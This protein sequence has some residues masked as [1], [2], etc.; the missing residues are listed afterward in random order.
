M[1]EGTVADNKTPLSNEETNDNIGLDTARKPDTRPWKERVRLFFYNS[2]EGSFLGRTPLSW[3]QIIAFYICFFTCL[4]GFWLLCWF[5]FVTTTPELSEGP[6][7][8]QDKSI[9]GTNPGVGIRPQMKDE[10]LEQKANFMSKVTFSSTNKQPNLDYA[11]E[12]KASLTNY[13][14]PSSSFKTADL[15]ECGEPPYGLTE[16]G[17]KICVYLKLNRI[18]GWSPTPIDAD[19]I[20]KAGETWSEDFV[21]HWQSQDNKNFVWMSCKAQNKEEQTKFEEFEYFP[22]NRGIDLKFFP[23]TKKEDE[24]V[25]PAP[26][27]AVMITPKSGFEDETTVVIEC[28]AFYKDVVHETK[29]GKHR[30]LVP[31]ELKRVK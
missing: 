29:M 18:W 22:E 20:I 17:S 1:K 4:L 2:E 30:G 31:F 19:D 10:K 6:R 28:R 14:L 24:E 21:R 25:P 16:S 7:W 9:I 12:I 13:S 8:Q 3:I 15:G 11:A 5:I 23:F 26:L 27:V